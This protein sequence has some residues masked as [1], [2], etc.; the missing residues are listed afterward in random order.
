MITFYFIRHGRTLWNH[1]GRYQGITDV[2]LNDIGKKQAVLTAQRLK[3]ISFDEIISSDLVR[4]RETAEAIAELHGKDVRVMK[5]FQ[6]LSFG[7]WEGLTFEEIERKWPGMI[8][9]MYHHPDTLRL[10]HGESFGDLQK[11]TMA[12]LK[13]IISEGDNKTYAIISH[14]AAIRTILCGLL[15]IPLDRSWNFS[16][17]NAGITCM[18]HYIGDRSILNFH[19]NV[20]H[21]EGL[22]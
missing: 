2:P 8:A 20:E 11:R 16:L 3:D 21:L 9:E 18:T 1:S 14:G 13:D 5:A 19:N 12:A 17:G 4:A 10:P 22:V 6:E 15:E 7:D